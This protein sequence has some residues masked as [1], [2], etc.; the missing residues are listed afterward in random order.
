MNDFIQVFPKAPKIAAGQA[1]LARQDTI[2]ETGEGDHSSHSARSHG[3]SEHRSLLERQPTE[4]DRLLDSATV[5]REREQL[6]R[7]LSLECERQLESTR[8]ST[9]ETYYDNGLRE[10]SSTLAQRDLIATVLDMK[11]DSR[12]EMHRISQRIGRL[13]DLL[14]ELV[15][16]LANDSEVSTPAD[17]TVPTIT[18]TLVTHSPSPVASTVHQASGTTIVVTQTTAQP[19]PPLSSSTTAIAASATAAISG[20]ASGSSTGGLNPILLRKR[21]SKSRKAP[22]PPKITSPEQTRLLD[23]EAPTSSTSA[24]TSTGR[25]RDF[26]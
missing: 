10:Q 5:Q 1:T 20:H 11:S 18:T 8:A 15:K 6:E 12:V 7:T 4:R 9:S 22:A 17:E 26:L 13:E 3:R 14:T 23:A 2:D 24:S 16:R 21:R 25:K 19:P